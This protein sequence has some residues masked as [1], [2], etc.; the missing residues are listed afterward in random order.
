MVKKRKM[1]AQADLELQWLHIILNAAFVW[2]DSCYFCV[3]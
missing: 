3:G 1:Y 2:R